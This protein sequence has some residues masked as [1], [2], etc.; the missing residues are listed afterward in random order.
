MD[1]NI[2]LLAYA[3]T[4]IQ[5]PALEGVEDPRAVALSLLDNVSLAISNQ[6]K[7][8]HDVAYF[9]SNYDPTGKSNSLAQRYFRKLFKLEQ[10]VQKEL[11]ASLEYASDSDDY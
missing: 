1:D 5:K 3:G 9:F 8:F 6:V 11:Q 7:F 2:G 10:K 4:N